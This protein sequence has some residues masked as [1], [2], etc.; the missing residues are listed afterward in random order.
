[1][2]RSRFGTGRPFSSPP[3]NGKTRSTP[4]PAASGS[5]VFDFYPMTP[6]EQLRTFFIGNLPKGIPDDRVIAFLELISGFQKFVRVTN[7]SGKPLNF[8]FVRFA[9]PPG[10]KVALDVLPDVEYTDND[11]ARSKLKLSVES[12][13]LEWLSVKFPHITPEVHQGSSKRDLVTKV[14][15]VISKWQ[16]ASRES[17]NDENPEDSIDEGD[18]IEFLNQSIKGSQSQEFASSVSPAMADVLRKEI[19]AF[20][21]QALR[22][23]KARILETEAY[24]RKKQQELEE[25]SAKLLQGSLESKA[26]NGDSIITSS[27]LGPLMKEF[28]EYDLSE[29]E[30]P[31]VDDE[32]NNE[33]RDLKLETKQL[34]RS[35]ED[36]ERLFRKRQERWVNREL[37]HLEAV[38]REKE[39]ESNMEER[40]KTAQENALRE[41]ASFSDYDPQSMQKYDYYSDHAHWSK[42]RNSYRRR[43]IERD[44]NDIEDERKENEALPDTAIRTTAVNKKISL[45]LSTAKDR[46]QVEKPVQ[47]LK[48]NEVNASEIIAQL[49]ND[50]ENKENI[51]DWDVQWDSLTEDIL[52]NTLRPLVENQILE[53]LGIQEEDLVNFVLDHL[54]SHKPAGELVSEL[55]MTLD[56]D[57]PVFVRTLWKQLILEIEMEKRLKPTN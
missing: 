32:G 48:D 37:A 39:R 27:E 16:Q 53:Y 8:G 14:N 41:Y 51:F 22:L 25:K 1:M 28:E 4:A 20:R 36:R 42:E 44:N 56:E 26:T 3:V 30:L 19:K 7:A 17:K 45:S 47:P 9:T 6:D 33:Q 29:E 24:E 2:S 40:L 43:E 34:E 18:L 38:K 15:F 35:R 55:E 21:E 31:L 23:E 49:K 5:A 52:S 54:R 13:T 46:K 11:G 57:A 50:I 12:N 10:T